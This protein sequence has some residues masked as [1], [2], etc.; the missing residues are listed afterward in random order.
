MKNLNRNASAKFQEPLGNL[1]KSCRHYR[2]VQKGGNGP[3]MA[4]EDQERP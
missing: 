1:W 3:R 2:E 4:G